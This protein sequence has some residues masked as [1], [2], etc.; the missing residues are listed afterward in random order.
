MVSFVYKFSPGSHAKITALNSVIGE[1]WFKEQVSRTDIRMIIL[2]VHINPTVADTTSL[3][4]AIRGYR[5][6]IPIVV[7]GGMSLVVSEMKET[8]FFLCRP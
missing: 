4:N 5:S 7:F 1:N 3:I 2:N 8:S 6:T